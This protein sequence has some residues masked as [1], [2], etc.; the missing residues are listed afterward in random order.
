MWAQ[1]ISL[2]LGIWLMV[3]PSAL[4]YLGAAQ[5]QDHILGPIIASVGCI[6]MWEI[7]RA[8]RWIN[9]LLGCWLIISPWVF[10]FEKPALINSLGV[11][12]LLIGCSLVKGK[13]K[14]LVGGGWRILWNKSTVTRMKPADL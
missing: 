3:A 13:M 6:A 4:G 9:V 8:L 7:A 11:G 12:A 5:T 2:C 14:L 1:A 10:D